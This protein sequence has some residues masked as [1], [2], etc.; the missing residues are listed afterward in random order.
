MS[1]F[2]DLS[3]HSLPSLP[4]R[5]SECAFRLQCRRYGAHLCVTPMVNA[6][7]FVESE[8][9]RNKV[10]ADVRSAPQ[11]DRPLI[12]QLAGHDPA[13]LVAAARY[14]ESIA[15]GVDINLGCPQGIARRG[16]Y[17]AYLLEECDLVVSIVEHLVAELTCAVTCKIRLFPDID[18]TLD[19][20]DRLARAGA[21]M[22]TVHGRTKEMKQAMTGPCDWAKIG[23][24][25]DRINGRIPVFANGGI[26]SHADIARCIEVTRAQGVM[27]SEAS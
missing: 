3:R 10:L 11:E 25:V 19:L 18:R 13:T 2:S 15:D 20:V 22:L 27:I 24:V 9:Y 16:R 21:F 6:R 7:S 17:G 12:V 8:G 14:V 23:Q 5:G 4:R 1:L 26:G